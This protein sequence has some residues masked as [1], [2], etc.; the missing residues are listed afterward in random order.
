MEVG[1]SAVDPHAPWPVNGEDPWR[2][3]DM[4]VTFS[5]KLIADFIVFQRFYSEDFLG[6]FLL[7]SSRQTV[8]VAPELVRR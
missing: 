3:M 5:R 1:V 6:S 2:V 7:L 4:A 8:E